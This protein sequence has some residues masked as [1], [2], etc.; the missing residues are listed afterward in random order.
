MSTLYYID[1][2]N[3]LHKS[4]RLRPL[5]SADNE[6]AREGLIDKVAHLCSTTRTRAV[7]VFDGRGKNVPETV[8]HYRG[9]PNLEVRYAPHNSS[10]DAVI[11]RAVYRHTNRLEVVVVSN[12]RGLRDLCAGMGALVMGSD[13]FLDT[14][15]DSRSETTQVLTKSRNEQAAFIEDGLSEDAIAA[16]K[17]L[18]DSLK[19]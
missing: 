19:K 13:S 8:E 9:V 15:R 1:G 6:T 10:A 16:L 17:R 7:I 18:R 3:V 4:R 14:C 11:E 2:Y 5:I 12:D